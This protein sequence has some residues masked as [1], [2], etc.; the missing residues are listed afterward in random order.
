MSTGLRLLV[1]VDPLLLCGEPRGD[2]LG[3]KPLLSFTSSG[4]PR[5]V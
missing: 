1:G 5:G 3:V 4:E 2:D